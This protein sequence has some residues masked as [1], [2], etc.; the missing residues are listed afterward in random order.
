MKFN[1]QSAANEQGNDG[2]Q[3]AGAQAA[4]PMRIAHKSQI[5]Q[6]SHMADAQ[7]RPK[8]DHSSNQDCTMKKRVEIVF[9]QERKRTV[10]GKPMCCPEQYW[11]EE[12]PK[13]DGCDKIGRQ[14]SCVFHLM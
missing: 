5:T 7:Q 9:R 13:N 14:S 2:E 1:Q 12:G 3:S 10:R 4:H 11:S 6:P 8:Q